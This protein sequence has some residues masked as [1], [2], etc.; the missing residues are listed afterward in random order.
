MNFSHLPTTLK[1]RWRDIAFWFLLVALI[2][3]RAPTWLRA[4]QQEGRAVPTLELPT[5]AQ[6][7]RL[8]YDPSRGNQALLFWASWC[9][10]C[11]IELSRFD[12]SVRAGKIPPEKI[13]AIS[14]D[15]NPNEYKKAVRERGYPFPTAWDAGGRAARA[16]GIEVTPTVVLVDN[17]GK[18]RSFSTGMS[19]IGPWRVR[20]FVSP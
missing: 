3:A 16:L 18:V 2:S 20:R 7:M 15:E 14:I 6:Q 1:K 8:L 5:E 13:L 17:Q 4:M 19:F 12:S 11:K 10:P 9:G